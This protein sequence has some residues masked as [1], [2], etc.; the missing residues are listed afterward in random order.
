MNIAYIT[1]SKIPSVYD[2]QAQRCLSIIKLF[3]NSMVD[4]VSNC[5][6]LRTVRNVSETISCA[7]IHIED[8]KM[9]VKLIK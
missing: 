3:D 4:I 6:I 5:K 8:K 2:A 7:S 1:S 9:L